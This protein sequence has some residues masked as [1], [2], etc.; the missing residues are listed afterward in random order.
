MPRRADPYITSRLAY[1]LR[2][3]LRG[4]YLDVACGTGNYTA[5]LAA[6]GGPWHGIDQSKLMISAA[7]PKGDFARWVVGDAARLPYR[8]GAFAGAMR[9][10]ATHHFPALSPPLHEAHRV[11]AAGRLV[12]LTATPEQ[13]SRF[14]LAEYFPQMIGRSAEQC[15]HTR[16]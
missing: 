4:L 2:V 12:V 3:D 1:H 15:R 5:A 16:Q 7:R 10:L 13:V 8:A 11:L 14:W 6:R 9:T